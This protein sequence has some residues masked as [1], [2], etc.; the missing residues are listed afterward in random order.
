M[1]HPAWN[2]LDLLFIKFLYA[3][4]PMISCYGKLCAESIY[5]NFVEIRRIH[6]PLKHRT[7]TSSICYHQAHD[8]AKLLLLYNFLLGGMICCLGGAYTGN[9]LHLVSI[10]EC[11]IALS[12]IP[13]VPGE[14]HHNFPTLQHLL[15]QNISFKASF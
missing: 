2:F 12:N 14:P 4:S 3:A 7:S 10:N 6:T 5:I 8:V 9:F 11:L 1:F 13:N 15:H